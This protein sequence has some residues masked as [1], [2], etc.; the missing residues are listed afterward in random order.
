MTFHRPC[1]RSSVATNAYTLTPAIGY[2][3]AFHRPCHRRCSIPSYSP[4]RW[5]RP[6]A[7][8]SPR[9][10]SSCAVAPLGSNPSRQTS[11]KRLMLTS[12][13]AFGRVANQ[14]FNTS[15]NSLGT[16]AHVCDGGG[17]DL[18][19]GTSV[20]NLEISSR[21]DRTSIRQG[22]ISRLKINIGYPVCF[23]PSDGLLDHRLNRL[24]LQRNQRCNSLCADQM[25]ASRA[26][27]NANGWRNPVRHRPE[28]TRVGVWVPRKTRAP[29][30]CD[31]ICILSRP[32]FPNPC[33][34]CARR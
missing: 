4:E 6:R 25:V 13:R 26:R 30:I 12:E 16:S 34:Q 10:R 3:I 14:D 11:A 22:I 20:L 19:I 8:I 9:I 28:R 21:L 1:H 5:K 23:P 18:L 29:A 15:P 27:R 32:R 33:H 24:I 7:R 2:S 31:P 17:K